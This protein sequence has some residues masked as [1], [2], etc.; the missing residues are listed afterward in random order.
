MTVADYDA[1]QRQ[2]KDQPLW[3]RVVPP[4]EQLT[5]KPARY[6]ARI[7]DADLYAAQMRVLIGLDP[8]EPGDRL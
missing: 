5:D 1:V 3:A 4:V 7:I 8:P 6:G 2:R